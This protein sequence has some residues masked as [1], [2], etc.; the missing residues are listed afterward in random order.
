MCF[1]VQR[2]DILQ[3]DRRIDLQVGA[4][5]KAPL[6]GS[7]KEEDVTFFSF[8]CEMERREECHRRGLR[9]APRILS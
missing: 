3:A 8:I 5:A 4:A 2:R 1:D 7:P 6:E 9:P